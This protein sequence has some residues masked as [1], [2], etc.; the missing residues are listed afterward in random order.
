M[1]TVYLYRSALHQHSFVRMCCNREPDKSNHHRTT[2][3]LNQL[4]L[5]RLTMSPCY[6]VKNCVKKECSLLKCCFHVDVYRVQ[7]L[8]SQL[9][10]EDVNIRY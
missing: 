8:E 5:E 3:D 9:K 1:L 2:S 10:F 4:C 6:K 7:T